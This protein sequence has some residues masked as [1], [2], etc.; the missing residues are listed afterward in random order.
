[1]PGP[2][3]AADPKGWGQAAAQQPGQRQLDCVGQ[4]EGEHTPAQHGEHSHR[5]GGAGVYRVV[6]DGAEQVA[7]DLTHD[8]GTFD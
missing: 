3:A 2:S 6:P 4:E 7:Q 5:P 1:M 8:G